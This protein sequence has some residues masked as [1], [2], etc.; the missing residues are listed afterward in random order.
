MDASFVTIQQQ[1]IVI[2]TSSTSTPHLLCQ[3][4]ATRLQGNGFWRARVF[5]VFTGKSRTSISK[6]NRQSILFDSS[7]S[8]SS[9]PLTRV[10]PPCTHWQPHKI[11]ACCKSR[12]S[13]LQG[14][15]KLNGSCKGRFFFLYLINTLFLAGI[16]GQPDVVTLTRPLFPPSTISPHQ[17]L[18]PSG[19]LI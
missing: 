6:D 15:L 3:P 4:A 19:L 5:Y 8:S 16:S 10:P 14:W 2:F 13:V 17:Y 11:L 7:G 12:K 9:K 18:C 1:L